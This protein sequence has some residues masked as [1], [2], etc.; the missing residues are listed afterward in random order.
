M[1]KPRATQIYVLVDEYDTFSY[2]SLRSNGTTLDRSAV[3]ITFKAFWS[4]MKKM[5]MEVNSRVFIT[6]ISPL[7]LADIGSGFNVSINLSFDED[8]TGLCGLADTD[9]EA[10]LR[11]VCPSTSDYQHHLS[12][13]KDFYNGYHFCDYKNVQTMYNTETCLSYLQVRLTFL[14]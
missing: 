1:T 9:I 5:L 13:M 14:L 12:Q 7:Y 8:V 6:G 10:A 11:K 2:D 3:D 4:A